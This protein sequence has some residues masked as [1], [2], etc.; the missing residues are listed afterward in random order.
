VFLFT[1]LLK[2]TFIEPSPIRLVRPYADKGKA[3][4]F[5]VIL[6]ANISGFRKHCGLSPGDLRGRRGTFE[7]K[8]LLIGTLSWHLRWWD[9]ATKSWP[10]YITTY[11]AVNPTLGAILI[12][13]ITPYRLRWTIVIWRALS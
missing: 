9:C 6:K 1:S 3:A 8:W 7:A 12:W 2:S 10:Y 5:R 4:L 11:G 13:Q